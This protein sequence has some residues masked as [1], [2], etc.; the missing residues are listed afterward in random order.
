MNDDSS[1][2]KNV[3]LKNS[4]LE[5]KTQHNQLQPG[6]EVIYSRHE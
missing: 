1:T 6:V 3:H 2:E 4:H 5:Q